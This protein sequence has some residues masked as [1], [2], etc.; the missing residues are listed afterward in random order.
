MKNC[1]SWIIIGCVPSTNSCR[2]SF[3]HRIH[4]ASLDL[5]PEENFLTWFMDLLDWSLNTVNIS[6]FKA[7]EV[8]LNVSFANLENLST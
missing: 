3:I 8:R 5:D 2:I 1:K 7:H 6:T 4:T